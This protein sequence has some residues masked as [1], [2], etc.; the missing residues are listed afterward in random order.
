MSYVRHYLMIAQDGAETALAEALKALQEKVLPLD[1]CE[2]VLLLRDL[3]K[4]GQFVFIERWVTADAHKAG[5][6][7]LG[8][9]ALAPVMAVLAQPPQAMSLTVA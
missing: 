4:Q 9:A 7:V 6:A 5:G 1:G 8:K 2:D 3:D